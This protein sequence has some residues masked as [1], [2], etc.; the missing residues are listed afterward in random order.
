M[1]LLWAERQA[2][3][4][5]RRAGNEIDWENV[6]EEIEDVANR[7]RDQIEGR[8]VVLCQHLLTWQF[9]P[10]QQSGSWRGSIIEARDRIARVVRN[11]PS[12]RVYPGEVRAEAYV[13]GRRRAEGET[14]LTM[15]A[16]CPWTIDQTLDHGFWP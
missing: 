6:A 7:A 15:P 11:N 14:G 16:E 8:L 2:H 9:Q 4:L 10:E 3:A 5:R 12:L 1:T 13:D